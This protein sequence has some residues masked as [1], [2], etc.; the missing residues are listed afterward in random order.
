[1]GV[2]A[3]TKRD[4]MTQDTTLGRAG[5]AMVTP[6]DAAEE[7]VLLRRMPYA[8]NLRPDTTD[9]GALTT[10]AAEEGRR[11]LRGGPGLVRVRAPG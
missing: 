3:R 1:M 2:T 11:D 5:S 6:D 7:A 8:G 4:D 10:V 9:E